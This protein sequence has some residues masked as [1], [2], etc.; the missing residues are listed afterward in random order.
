MNPNDPTSTN[1]APAAARHCPSCRGLRLRRVPRRDEDRGAGAAAGLRRYRCGAAGCNWSGLLQPGG[2]GRARLRQARRRWSRHSSRRWPAWLAGTALAATAAA[3]AVVVAGLWRPAESDHKALRLAAGESYLGT[4]LTPSHRLL[5][6]VSQRNGDGAVAASGAPAATKARAALHLRQFCAW[7]EPGRD[8]YRGTPEQA[9]ALAQLPPEVVQRISADIRA[10]RHT[11]QVTITNVAIRADRSAREFDPKQIA[12]TFGQ[13]L[14]LDTRVN[15]RTDHAER[16]ELYEAT[17]E[18]GRVYAV[19][20][21]RVCGNVS[22][23]GQRGERVRRSVD[24]ATATAGAGAGAGPGAEATSAWRLL[25]DALITA[26]DDGKSQLKGSRLSQQE[27]PE[28]ATLAL[29]LAALLVLVVL[30]QGR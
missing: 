16:A 10:G 13:T 6:L 24:G 17:A 27:I 18:N 29:A 21:P 11:D 26:E 9:L 4:P 20:V 19:M 8:P 22:V 3:A 12:M 30:R 23:L 25:P 14:C 15:F 2:S 28:P 5:K 7:G 1:D